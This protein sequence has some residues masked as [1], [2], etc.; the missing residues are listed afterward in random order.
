MD[1]F[2][3]QIKGSKFKAFTRDSEID[4]HRPHWWSP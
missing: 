1:G 3:L 2:V 4:I